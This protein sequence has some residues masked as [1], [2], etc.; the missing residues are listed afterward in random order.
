MPFKRL[1]FACAAVAGTFALTSC[2]SDDSSSP[3]AALTPKQACD[4]LAGQRIEAASI[5]LP[6]TGATVASASLVAAGEAGNANGEFC[7]VLGA[8]HPVDKNAP[9]INFEVNLPT[10]WNDKALH[11]GGGGYNGSLVTGLG[12][13][14]FGPATAPTP[15]AQGYVTLGSDSGHSGSGVD[16]SF[17]LNDEA[18]ANFGGDQLKKTRDAALALVRS[19]YGKG[20][21][22]MY[23]AGNS[24]GGHEGFLVIQRWPRDYQGVIATHPVYNFTMLTMD[25]NFQARAYYANGGAGFLPA[26]KVAALQAAVNGACDAL[27]GATDGIIA[28]VA[29]CRARFDVSTLRCPGGADTGTACLSDAQIGSVRSLDSPLQLDF[30]L[31]GGLTS[32]PRW[33][34]LEGADWG[35]IFNL[36]TRPVPSTPPTPFADFG[37]HVLGDPLIRY[38]VVRDAAFDSLAFDPRAY[39]ARVAAVS[40]IIDANSVDI[41]AFQAAGGKLLLMHGT[42]DSA[43][44]PYNTVEYYER[45]RAAFGQASLDTFVRFYLVPGF[46]HGSGPFVASWDSL[47]ALERWVETGTAPGTLVAVDLNQD[48]NGRSRPMCVYPAWPRYS[49]SGP[50]DAAASFVCATS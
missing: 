35:G 27:D 11:F 39:R 48:R 9:D 37:L 31:A 1:A 49:G 34:V 12:Q 23:F 21:S 22:R 40:A 4:A 19:R 24:Q 45:L 29:G 14:P 15:L 36:G 25:Q 8:I 5:G 33:P 32:F 16:A 47:G 43:V 13:V 30:A 50:V 7:K 6:T 20:P 41:G 2:G 44:S 46:G 18:L 26:P 10:A 42:T 3:A 38:F 28:N 17:G